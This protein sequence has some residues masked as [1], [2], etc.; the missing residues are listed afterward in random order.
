MI[1]EVGIEICWLLPSTETPGMYMS[2]SVSLTKN[3]ENPELN[4]IKEYSQAKLDLSWTHSDTCMYG[5]AV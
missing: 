5:Q 4:C 1:W 3:K 2:K